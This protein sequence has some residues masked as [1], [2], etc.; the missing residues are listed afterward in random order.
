MTLI[1]AAE[2]LGLDF[3]AATLPVALTAVHERA[4]TPGPFAYVVTPNVDHM[5]R[6]AREPQRRALYAD[7]WL[8]LND[9]RILELLAQRSGIELPAS[10]GADLVEQ[11]LGDV[12]DPAE[13]VTII[14]A[15]EA[16]IEGLRRRYGLTDIRWHVPP[17]GLARKPA[18]IAEA[19][20][21]IAAQRAR[22][23]FIA[24][25]APQQ[26]MV[27]RAAL[28]RGD[29]VGVGLCIGAGLEFAADVKT[30]APYWMRRARLEW[31]H[32]LLSE[33]HRLARRYLVDGP[34]ILQLWA[35]WER[36]RRASASRL[37]IASRS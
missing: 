26:E 2:F 8:R 3:T 31:A 14:G 9:S 11:L 10:P 5:V 33:P 30:R 1:R 21:F 17:M 27:A 22:F 4:E 18:A 15:S 6:L 13:P 19:A 37:S 20:A 16:V 12:V 35:S 28:E 7:A 29:C 23:V 36:D 34:Q 32:R 24:V 25:G